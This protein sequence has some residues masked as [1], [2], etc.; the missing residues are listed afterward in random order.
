[1]GFLL[2]A[3]VLAAAGLAPSAVSAHGTHVHAVKAAAKVALDH[4]SDHETRAVAPVVEA[5]TVVAAVPHAGGPF[6]P[7]SSDCDCNGC[8]GVNA[9]CC[10]VALE[11]SPAGL[12]GANPPTPFLLRPM[13]ALM[14]LPPEAL[15]K[16]PR[17]FA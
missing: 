16:P 14:G 7:P 2:A 10:G 6:A 8:C 4:E 12:A 15:P 9:N 17:S 11:P 1:M 13:R 5:G 3:L